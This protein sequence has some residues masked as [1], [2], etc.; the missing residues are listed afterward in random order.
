MNIYVILWV[1][2]PALSLFTLLPELCWL[3]LGISPFGFCIFQ[4][5]PI[6][7][8]FKVFFPVFWKEILQAHFLFSLIWSWNQ[9]L[10][11]RALSPFNE[12]PGL[13]CGGCSWSKT[14]S[15]PLSRDKKY[16]F[17][18][19]QIYRRTSLCFSIHLCVYELRSLWCINDSYLPQEDLFYPP[20]FLLV[21]Y[22]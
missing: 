6:F 11:Q 3:F 9:P 10:L 18:E 17:V 14:T 7:F 22:W 2:N 21:A 12:D 4:W 16:I 1:F 15:S 20:P 19:L 8:L 5:A 13:R